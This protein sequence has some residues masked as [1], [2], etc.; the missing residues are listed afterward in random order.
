MPKSRVVDHGIRGEPHSL[1]AE[2]AIRRV[3]ERQHGVVT[4]SQIRDLGLGKGL[5]DH[6]LAT[7]RIDEVHRGVYALNEVLLTREGRWLAAALAIGDGGAL[8]HHSAA[9]LW[10][11]RRGSGLP[12][13]VTCPRAL[14]PRP[15][16]NLHRLPLA[17]DEITREREIPVT[18]PARTLL[19][20]AAS[21]GPTALRRAAR[22]AEFLQLAST[23]P[24]LPEL[25]ERYPGRTGIRAARALLDAGWGGGRTKSN[26]EERFLTLIE[27]AGL[28]KPEINAIVDVDG[29][30]FEVDF[31]WRRARLI[32]E[33]DDLSSHGTPS[34]FEADRRRDRVLQAAGFHVLRFTSRQIATE[35]RELTR[36]LCRLIDAAGPMHGGS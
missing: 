21:L 14:R 28:P 33:V 3:A 8:S 15:G 10:R 16:I 12:P 23:G 6:R 7:R 20:L 4:R 19:D 29:E 32:A 2:E 18:T 31:I 1:S 35:A 13:H 36:D 5:I 17:D 25:V 11:I 30:W 22:E 34:A 9:V 24:S 26:H 27:R